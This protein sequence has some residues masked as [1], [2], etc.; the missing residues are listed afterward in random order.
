MYLCEFHK[1]IETNARCT[2]LK[3][4]YVN[5]TKKLKLT[6]DVLGFVMSLGDDFKFSEKVLYFEMNLKLE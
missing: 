2:G 4:T 1:K 5:F 3:C 6:P